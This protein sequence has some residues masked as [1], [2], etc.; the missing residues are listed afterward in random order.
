MSSKHLLLGFIVKLLDNYRV[1]L[2]YLFIMIQFSKVGK[3]FNNWLCN[4][5]FDQYN[6]LPIF[7]RKF[8]TT[9]TARFTLF[10]RVGRR[11]V[12]YTRSCWAGWNKHKLS[13]FPVY[14]KLMKTSVKHRCAFLLQP[15]RRGKLLMIVLCLPNHCQVIDYCRR[16]CKRPKCK[17]PFWMAA[18]YIKLLRL[19][20]CHS[21][22]TKQW[23]V[24]FLLCFFLTGIDIYNFSSYLYWKQYF[25]GHCILDVWILAQEVCCRRSFAYSECSHGFMVLA[26]VCP[27]V[28]L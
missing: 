9:I 27:S 10:C 11:V 8:V 25:R 22:I 16:G 14:S 28:R 13:L 7:Q 18:A 3:I 4:Y 24:S 12:A 5:S 26:C 2:Y 21:F 17:S 6:M 15:E 23:D 19:P 1:H 20:S